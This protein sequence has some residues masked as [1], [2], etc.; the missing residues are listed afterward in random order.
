M[1]MLWAR[2]KYILLVHLLQSIKKIIV[3]LRS[4]LI[5]C[6]SVTLHLSFVFVSALDNNNR[7]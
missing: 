2:K 3:L 1:R 7:Q 5:F 4:L 6:P